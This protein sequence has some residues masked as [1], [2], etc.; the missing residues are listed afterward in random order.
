MGKFSGTDGVGIIWFTKS[1]FKSARKLMIDRAKLPFTFDK[2]QKRANEALHFVESE[3]GKPIRVEF[4]V[5]RFRA[6][7][8]AK[9]LKFDANGR[10]AFAADP[11]N[12]PASSKH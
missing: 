1:N 2:W 7:C 10:N 6:Y 4:D 9:G 3:G 11:A 8:T 12:W 5:E